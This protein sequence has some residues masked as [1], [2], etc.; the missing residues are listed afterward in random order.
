MRIVAWPS[1]TNVRALESG[2]IERR[3][4]GAGATQDLGRSAVAHRVTEDD[5]F[6]IEP[7]FRGEPAH[8]GIERG[9]ADGDPDE[10]ARIERG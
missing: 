7:D 10:R 4:A 3:D 5:H 8:D 1:A 6:P 9:V 2:G